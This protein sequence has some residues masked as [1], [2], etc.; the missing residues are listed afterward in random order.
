MRYARARRGRLGERRAVP[1]AQLGHQRALRV[2]LP[3]LVLADGVDGLQQRAGAQRVRLS[4]QRRAQ[5]LR[6]RAELVGAVGPRHARRSG[7]PLGRRSALLDDGVEHVE[8]GRAISGRG[9]ARRAAGLGAPGGRRACGRR[10]RACNYPSKLDQQKAERVPLEFANE[11]V[12]VRRAEEVC[13]EE[14]RKDGGDGGVGGEREAGGGHA[15]EQGAAG[16]GEGDSL[17]GGQVAAAVN[18]K[19][20]VVHE[21]Q[22]QPE[23][24]GQEEGVADEITGGPALRLHLKET[25]HAC[26]RHHR[27][28]PEEPPRAT[29]GGERAKR[30]DA[31]AQVDEEAEEEGGAAAAERVRVFVRCATEEAVRHREQG[32]R[33]RRGKEGQA[34]PA[35]ERADEGARR[36]Q[37]EDDALDARLEH[38]EP[39]KEA[40]QPFSFVLLPLVDGR[41]EARA[42]VQ[43]V[44]VGAREHAADQLLAGGEVVTNPNKETGREQREADGDEAGDPVGTRGALHRRQ[45]HDDHRIGSKVGE[46]DERHRQHVRRL[47]HE[48][49]LAQGGTLAQLRRLVLLS[50][51]AHRHA[52]GLGP[53]GGEG[54]R[55]HRW[56]GIER[57]RAAAE[58][59]V[60]GCR[61]PKIPTPAPNEAI[62]C[63]GGCCSFTDRVWPAYTDTSTLVKH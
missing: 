38:L 8:Q 54:R 23:E 30:R 12:G 39:N 37:A 26:E 48:H 2:I 41:D 13:D 15:E 32:E 7:G 61:I 29:G 17:R 6:L 22:W 42:H 31:P 43:D 57:A 35:V 5:P 21:H 20:L 25:P 36:H 63:C 44:Q 55:H 10:G 45:L 50:W 27:P 18:F 1:A 24:E 58:D 60:P 33:E 46:L 34:A 59:D 52:V 4:Q 62:A 16:G 47:L 19:E 49:D 56:L 53:L 28:Q 51:R 11:A 14:R 3:R 40:V 9:G